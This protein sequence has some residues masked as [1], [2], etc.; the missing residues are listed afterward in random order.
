MASLV[1]ALF[2][3]GLLT[4]LLPC[5]FP[6]LPIVLGVSIA[7]HSK[8][9][10]LMTVAGMLV[11]FV[12][13]IFLL[14]V[15]LNEFVELAD[16][17]RIATLEI[18]FLFGVGFLLEKR[19]YRMIGAVLA[20]LFFW[21]KG[22]VAMII[23]AAA[24]V[25]AMEIGGRIATK[26]QQLGAT[27]QGA[28]REEF[29]NES[30]LTAFLVG[31]TMGLVWVP[32][33]GPAL[34][35][36]LTIV[37]EQPGSLAALYLLSYA[38]G[39]GIP[40]LLIGYGG[41]AAVHSVRSLS[42]FSGRI[43][44]ASG[45]LLILS[46][47][48]IA[49]NVFVNLQTSGDF[50]NLG[51]AIEQR[52]FGPAS[53]DNEPITSDTKLPNYG[54]A[55]EEFIDAGEWFNS[56]PLQLK[57]LKGK[58][59]LIDFWTYSCINCIRTLPYIQAYWEKYKD[60]P[61][62]LIGVHTPEFTFEKSP[63]NV[64]AAIK[65]YGLTYPVV[66]DNNYGTWRAFDN[67]YWPAKYLIDAKGNIRYTHFGEG[68][69]G[70]TDAAIASLLKEIGAGSGKA[71]DLPAMPAENDRKPVTRETYLHS[72][73]W[74][75]FANAMGA[76]DPNEH[77][78]VMPETL[79]LHTFAL[80]GVW[81]LI[82]DERQVL[83]GNAGKIRIHALAGEVNLVLGTEDGKAVQ[84][85]VIVDGKASKSLTIKGHDLYALF[86]GDYG[87]HDIVLQL[88]GGNVAAYAFTFGG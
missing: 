14:N 18:L 86:K 85:D 79:P 27:T 48:G 20:G 2:I 34:G 69:Y 6:L 47:I 41:Q 64:A 55:P 81:Q 5:I 74:S 60:Q 63:T 58:V 40:L 30:L 42:R 29:G 61:F 68:R 38:V 36:V 87:E 32:C 16:I 46:A 62:V 80:D 71:M 78:Y 84:A 28:V 51:N 37:R 23:A 10:P 72:R 50:G 15:L 73:S 9:R 19:S 67:H 75:A 35:F 22:I 44:Q 83:Q 45:A 52:L 31:C 24:G 49:S 33:A 4:I 77:M 17:V 13:S 7:G 53:D 65:K 57:D 76:P 21:D 26:I 66:Q 59:V 3:A 39:A 88:H 70:E 8:M 54:K 82:D 11:S 25:I 43:K 56:A 12:A 1:I